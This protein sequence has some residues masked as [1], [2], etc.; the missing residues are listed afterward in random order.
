MSEIA[1]EVYDWQEIPN[2]GSADA[3]AAGCQC[4]V[5]DNNRGR[6]APLPEGRWWI[7]V[8]CPVHYG[9]APKPDVTA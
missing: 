4:A 1:G 6:F 3:Q 9:P 5:L 7:T 2:P 8:G